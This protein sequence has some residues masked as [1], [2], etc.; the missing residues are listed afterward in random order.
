MPRSYRRPQL[1]RDGARLRRPRSCNLRIRGQLDFNSSKSAPRQ[2][3]KHQRMPLTIDSELSA[4]VDGKVFSARSSAVLPDCHRLE[5]FFAAETCMLTR[6]FLIP[7]LPYQSRKPSGRTGLELERI[8]KRLFPTW[9][10]LAPFVHVAAKA[11]QA[12]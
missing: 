1:L 2:A 7:S 9:S 3:L 8:R 12:S 10:V 6:T 4:G 11:S 5:L